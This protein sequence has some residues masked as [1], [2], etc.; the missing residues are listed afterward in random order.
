VKI[1]EPAELEENPGGNR[2]E[3]PGGKRPEVVGGWVDR[4]G[5]DAG[6]GGPVVLTGK[7]GAEEEVLAGT[8]ADAKDDDVSM[9]TG[10]CDCCAVAV[11]LR[12]DDGGGGGSSLGQGAVL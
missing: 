2:P 10:V 3:V 6:C 8:I 4:P 7:L 1:E 5:T 12:L 11:A 9:E